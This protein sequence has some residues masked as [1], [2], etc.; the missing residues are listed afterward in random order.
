MEHIDRKDFIVS[1]D[2]KGEPIDDIQERPRAQIVERIS[3]AAA[4]AR[5]ALYCRML[6]A[7]QLPSQGGRI[8]ER[9]TFDGKEFKYECWPLPP[10]KGPQP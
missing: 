9:A 3:V 7:G 8:A 5:E 1:T 2:F 6:A 10:A 4:K